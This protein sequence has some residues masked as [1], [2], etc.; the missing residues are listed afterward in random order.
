MK[1]FGRYID[2]HIKVNCFKDENN[3]DP[4]IKMMRATSL[5]NFACQGKS[6][7]NY[8]LEKQFG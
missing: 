8:N 5:T 2:N 6:T 4:E 7:F 1:T 3:E